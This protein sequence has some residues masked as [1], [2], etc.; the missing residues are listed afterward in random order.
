MGM[1]EAE[2]AFEQFAPELVRRCMTSKEKFLAG[3]F[4]ATR[5]TGEC[6]WEEDADGIWMTG[7][8][9]SFV[10]D[11]EDVRENGFVFCP[12][13]GKSLLPAPYQPEDAAKA[14]GKEEP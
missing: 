7:C 14:E 12:Y 1:D 10:F 13:C 8:S 4:A 2:L 11:T 3:Y 6:I 5:Q 9:K